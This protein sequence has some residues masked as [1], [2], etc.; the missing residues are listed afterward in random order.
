MKTKKQFFKE[1]II[2]CLI[3]SIP[4]LSAYFI[5]EMLFKDNQIGIIS[6]TLLIYFLSA[7][8]LLENWYVDDKFKELE[9]EIKK[10]KELKE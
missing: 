2:T 8:N 10:L 7:I 6:V 9:K 1:N 5:L 3:L 4:T